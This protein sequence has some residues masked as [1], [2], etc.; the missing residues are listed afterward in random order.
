M[1]QLNCPPQGCCQFPILSKLLTASGVKKYYCFSSNP[2][3]TISKGFIYAT[4]AKLAY[5]Y[6]F[7]AVKPAI[8]VWV[9][10]RILPKSGS[11]KWPS[12]IS[13]IRLFFA[14][15]ETTLIVPINC[16]YLASYSYPG[17]NPICQRAILIFFFVGNLSRFN[18]ERL[19]G[20]KIYWI[21]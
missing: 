2:N 18:V 1:P 5:F 8:S 19:S 6:G 15:R 7:L 20:S 16:Q 4:F 13:L 12:L 14:K 10:I 9:V 17:A 21:I 3:I 11:F